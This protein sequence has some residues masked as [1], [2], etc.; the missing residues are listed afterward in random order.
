MKRYHIIRDGRLEAATSTREEALDLIQIKMS[1]E[2]HPFLKANY[3]IIY[4][5]EEFISYAEAAARRT[6]NL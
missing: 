1:H 6:L 4:G 2:T 3:S 5:E